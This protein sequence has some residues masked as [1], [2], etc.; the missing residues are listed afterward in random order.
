MSN[1][2]RRNALSLILVPSPSLSALSDGQP[3]PPLQVSP[4]IS[5]QE[6]RPVKSPRQL[7]YHLPAPPKMQPLLSGSASS[8][9][10]LIVFSQTSCGGQRPLSQ[11]SGGRPHSR[12]SLLLI[13]PDKEKQATEPKRPPPV[14]FLPTPSGSQKHPRT[15][16]NRSAVKHRA[17]IDVTAAVGWVTSTDD[18]EQNQVVMPSNRSMRT[19]EG[20]QVSAKD[21]AWDKGPR[22]SPFLDPPQEKQ[23]AMNVRRAKE[24]HRVCHNPDLLFYSHGLERLIQL[25]TDCRFLTR[26]HRILCYRPHT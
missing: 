10:P 26:S 16:H 17:R 22:L 2:Q 13:T 11:L 18:V 23:R 4:S 7:M 8:D 19:R 5:N 15:S 6:R 12:R 25:A 3:R 1:T 9:L 24:I 20:K 21:D 14:L